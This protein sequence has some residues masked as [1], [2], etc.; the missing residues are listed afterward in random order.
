[1]TAAELIQTRADHSNVNMGL[2]AWKGNEVR[3]TDVTIAKNYLKETEIDD[4]NR[5]VVMWFDFAEDQA[6]RRKQ[7]FMKDWQEK[8]DAFL[9]FNDRDVLPDAG[10]VKKKDAD[11]HARKEYEKF[12]VKRREYKESMAETEYM[13]QLE[14]AAKM[15]PIEKKGESENC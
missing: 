14:E 8:L 12:E 1:M 11:G 5:I 13:T 9:L 4:L 6:K 2:T 15:L 10:K 7:V 3:K